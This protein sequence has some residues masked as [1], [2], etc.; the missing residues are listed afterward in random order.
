M[1][2]LSRRSKSEAVPSKNR[3][4]MFSRLLQ[5]PGELIASGPGTHRHIFTPREDRAFLG[6]GFGH[7]FRLI[8]GA[9]K[10]A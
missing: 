1:Q 10:G 6:V 5:T 8:D 2:K 9:A 4:S 3:P 7:P